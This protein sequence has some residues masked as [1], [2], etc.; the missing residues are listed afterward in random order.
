MQAALVTSLRR[1]LASLGMIALEVILVSEAQAADHPHPYVS[2]EDSGE[3]A[4]VDPE[5]GQVLQ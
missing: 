4:V 1:C 3:I 2:N 5:A